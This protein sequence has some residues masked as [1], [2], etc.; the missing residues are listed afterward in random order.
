M[1]PTVKNH[2]VILVN[3]WAIRSGI[4]QDDIVYFNAPTKEGGVYVKRIVGMPPDFYDKK[5]SLQNKNSTNKLELKS[6][7]IYVNSRKIL[8]DYLRPSVEPGFPDYEQI[9]L[10]L[11]YDN[12]F[13]LGDNR[14]FSLDSRDF[15][16]IK[17]QDIIGKYWMKIR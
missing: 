17:R 4:N 10:N 15:G 8:Q 3:K 13:V 14:R 12:Y 16:P 6:D 7:G 11:N 5:N 1:Y 2:E 9:S